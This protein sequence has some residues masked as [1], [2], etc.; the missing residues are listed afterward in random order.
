[1]TFCTGWRDGQRGL[2]AKVVETE[3]AEQRGVLTVS[4]FTRRDTR[5]AGRLTKQFLRWT[6][7]ISPAVALRCDML[8]G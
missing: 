5:G 7:D 1:M 4:T 3:R 6:S 8:E 2:Y